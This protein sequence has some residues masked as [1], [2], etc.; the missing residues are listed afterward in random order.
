MR[1]AA[2]LVC[3]FVLVGCDLAPR[4][5]LKE[6]D[7]AP[8]APSWTVPLTGRYE[9]TIGRVGHDRRDLAARWCYLDLA[10]VDGVVHAR[11]WR[12]GLAL[13]VG[14]ATIARGGRLRVT[15]V[16]AA[17]LE[18]ARDP[19]P[20]GSGIPVGE[21]AAALERW[22][23]DAVL[24]RDR[25]LDRERAPETGAFQGTATIEHTPPGERP[26]TWRSQFNA[27][28]A[29]AVDEDTPPELAAPPIVWLDVEEE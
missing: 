16:R 10:E 3:S 28:F 12:P 4:A 6:L 13:E 26:R 7:P 2:A 14:E 23:L 15:I 18:P 9:V 21:S 1:C 20:D 22:N 5:R 8:A 24:D 25:L 29:D 11:A 17:V 19:G 27:R